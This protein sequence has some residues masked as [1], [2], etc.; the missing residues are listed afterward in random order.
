MSLT[1]LA[2]HVQN[3]GSKMEFH[4]SEMSKR[5]Y[6]LQ[7]V[8]TIKFSYQINYHTGFPQS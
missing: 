7:S 8:R 6:P 5:K 4:V 3:E 2:F 1:L